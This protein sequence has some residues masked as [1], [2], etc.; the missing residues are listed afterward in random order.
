MNN[1]INNATGIWGLLIAMAF[2]VSAIVQLTKV[3]IP[4]PTKAWVILVSIMTMCAAL[5]VAIN[6]GIIAVTV[7]NMV[8]AM[9][10]SLLVAYIAMYGF[11]TLK[12]LWNRLC[13]GESGLDGEKNE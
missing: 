12:E 6:S 9:F 11:D 2:V 10:G 13:N 7:A 5:L 1:I 3:Y 4:V 8:L